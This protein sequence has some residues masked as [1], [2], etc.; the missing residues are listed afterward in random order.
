MQVGCPLFLI[1]MHIMMAQIRPSSPDIAAIVPALL[2][3]VAAITVWGMR[4]R[5]RA[6]TRIPT[7]YRPFWSAFSA[8]L[9]LWAIAAVYPVLEQV[10]NLAIILPIS[11]AASLLGLACWVA[12][13]L[14]L[15]RP[16]GFAIRTGLLLDALVVII[17][18]IVL[19]ERLSGAIG[20][21]GHEGGWHNDRHGGY[22][23]QGSPFSWHALYLCSAF[24]L[25]AALVLTRFLVSGPLTLPQSLALG[26]MLAALPSGWEWWG[27]R[28]AAI[29]TDISRV[30]VAVLA[31]V[32]VTAVTRDR[33]GRQDRQLRAMWQGAAPW[34]PAATTAGLLLLVV[35]PAILPSLATEGSAAG[36]PL[37]ATGDTGISRV[38][39]A[40]G[41]LVGIML[42]L[43]RGGMAGVEAESLRRERSYLVGQNEEY[44]RLAISDALTHLFNKGYFEYR[45]KTEWERSQRSKQPLSLIALDLDNFKQVNDRLGHAKGDELLAEVGEA[46]RAAVRGIDCPCRVGGDEFIVILP[47][48]D[49][50]GAAIVAERLRVGVVEVLNHLNLASFSSVSGGISNYPATSQTTT[51]LLEQ[52]DAAL[53]KAKQ[54]GK[55]QVCMWSE[56]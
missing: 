30:A 4:L 42:A 31:I 51:E 50:E 53:Y 55:N 44:V 2:P 46:I 24:A 11:E 27:T 6:L 28:E 33:Q 35:V 14:L 39:I 21:T 48:T 47:Q 20:E 43:V 41:A 25:W 54:A 38:V 37:P 13:L 1:T 10:A 26:T 49:V 45:L 15:H 9:T 19:V 52:A 29:P 40:G 36:Q 16:A 8:G 17:G 7:A 18:G 32:A 23:A 56:T 34:L 22:L 12:A 3:V 5:A